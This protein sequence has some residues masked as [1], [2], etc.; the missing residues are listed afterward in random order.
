MK[1]VGPTTKRKSARSAAA[2]ALAFESHW[3]PRS[4][5]LMAERT[6]QAVRKAMTKTASHLLPPVSIPKTWGR[7]P[8]I[9]KAPRPSED[10][11]PKSVARIATVSIVLP[12]G[13]FALS[14]MS[15]MSVPLMRLP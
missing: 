1:T 15:G 5:P 6:K 3:M 10:A 4:M 14:P 11:D 7:P 2:I 8:V 9:C 13:P 12:A